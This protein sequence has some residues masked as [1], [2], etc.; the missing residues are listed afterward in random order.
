MKRT[1]V[2]FV[3]AAAILLV[4]APR[5]HAQ[6]PPPAPSA[7]DA[8]LT[9]Q[10]AAFLALPEATRKDAQDALVWLGFYNGVVDGDFGPRTRDAILAFQASAK[11]PADGALSPPELRA[12]L[13]A[14]QKARDAAGFKIVT[15]PRTGAKIGAPTKLLGPR[16]GT[17]LDVTSSVD[18][19]LSALYARVSAPTATRKIA[20]KA[21]KPDEFFVVSGQEG[22]TSF[23]TRFEKNATASS[24][25]R[26]FTF[27]YPSAQAAALER[28]ALAVA[29]SFEAFPES[30]R[31]PAASAAAGASIAP[32]TGPA[33][34]APPPAPAA[35]AL[36]IAPGKALTA[37]KA[38]DCPNPTVG[39]KP[40][41]FERADAATGL[42]IL[43]GDFGADGEAPRFGS[44]GPDVVVLGFAGERLAASPASLAGGEARPVV[45]AAV[46]TSGGG[47]PL[48]DREGALVGLMAPI[49]GE[50]KRV[51]GVA[52]AA[53]HA[54]IAPDAVRAF[55]G[56]GEPAPTGDPALSAGEIAAREK[57][58]VIAVFCQK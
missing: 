30:A 47:G 32:E 55:L 34:P 6:T 8:A 36:I 12:L 5:A 25:I 7:A 35:T 42:A 2:G 21:I 9:A 45:V 1:A 49:N 4:F 44:P 33:P 27:A 52:L 26:G 23:Y 54:I 28:V 13:A 20:Y 38:D 19:D 53:P 3:V 58:A 56:S 39:G 41:R 14:A 40:V 10:K 24:P 17:K 29:N 57:E 22:G 31:P 15:D 51:G 37:L 46:E 11:A 18:P 16:A 43:A 50:P 48:F